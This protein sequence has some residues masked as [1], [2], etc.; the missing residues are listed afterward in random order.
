MI[1]LADEEQV[2]GRLFPQVQ[3]PRAFPV[4]GMRPRARLGSVAAATGA[5]AAPRH[6]ATSSPSIQCRPPGIMEYEADRRTLS[7]RIAR[8]AAAWSCAEGMAAEAWREG[9]WTGQT[10]SHRG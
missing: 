3:A 5:E 10:V 7:S 4:T 1:I 8:H 9:E 6:C 2:R